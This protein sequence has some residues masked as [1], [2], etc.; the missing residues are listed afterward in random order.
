MPEP[1]FVIKIIFYNHLLELSHDCIPKYQ[2]S[3]VEITWHVK[4]PGSEDFIL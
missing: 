1:K 3:K 4:Y 2:A